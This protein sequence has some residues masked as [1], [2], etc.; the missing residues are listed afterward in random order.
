MLGSHVSRKILSTPLAK[1][2][3]N[4]HFCQ[5]CHFRQI[6][7][8]FGTLLGRLI[9]SLERFRQHPWRNFARIAIFVK[10]VIF[11]KFVIFAKFANF[12]G[13]FWAG[14]NIFSLKTL[15]TPSAKFRQNRHFCQIC[16]CR[17]IRQLF[18]TLLGRLRYSLKWYVNILGK[19]LPDSSAC[20]ISQISPK[21]SKL[22]W[23]FRQICQFRHCLHF[24][25]YQRHLKAFFFCRSRMLAPFVFKNLGPSLFV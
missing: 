17:Q 10:F 5:I 18:G 7:Q 14:S 24:W 2:R 15:L 23:K 16:R 3:Q 25:T 11:T 6:R 19:I 22:S 12:L 1:F 20:L 13:P 8:L 4:R 21:L 9:Y